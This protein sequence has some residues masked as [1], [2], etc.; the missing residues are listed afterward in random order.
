MGWGSGL[1]VR[2]SVGHR[3]SSD[4][5]LL[6]L[7]CRPLAWEPPRAAGAALKKTKKKK[8]KR[9]PEPGW[10]NKYLFLTVLKA[11]KSKIKMPGD[12]VSGK[13]LIPDSLVPS[14]LLSMSAHEGT[15]EL[16]EALSYGP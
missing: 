6:W 4:A 14:C 7:W 16:S 12:L 13:G 9:I 8:K 15:R 3:H 11:W 10:L 5:A 1:A 2:C